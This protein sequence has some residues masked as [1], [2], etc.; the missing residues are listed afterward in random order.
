MADAPKKISIIDNPSISELYANK[1]IA[2]SFDGGAVTITLG[3]TRISAR[4]G[5]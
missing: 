4:A 2:T 3:T 5:W 1:L